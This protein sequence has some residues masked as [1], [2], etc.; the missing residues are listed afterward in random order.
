MEDRTSHGHCTAPHT[1]DCI[2]EAWGPDRA[3]CMIEALTALVET[4][5]VVANGPATQVVPLV[6]GQGNDAEVLVSLLEDVIYNLDV[7][8][9]VPVRFHLAETDNGG[10]TGAMEVVGVHEV[11]AVGPVPKAVSYHGLSMMK[12]NGSWR[13][14]VLIDV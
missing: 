1:A 14:R 10:I 6:A 5:A 2:I 8:S 3:S 9:V 13:C 11:E 4:F 12:H 7:R